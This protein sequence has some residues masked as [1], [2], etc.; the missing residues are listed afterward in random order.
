MNTIQPKNPRSR[1]QRIIVKRSYHYYNKRNS[2]SCCLLLMA[3]EQQPAAAWSWA[4]EI[5]NNRYVLYVSLYLYSNASFT[6]TFTSHYTVS[7]HY[8][9]R[10]DKRTSFGILSLNA[11]SLHFD[12]FPHCIPAPCKHL[13]LS[14][15][16]LYQ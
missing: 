1:K 6:L 4:I 16:A 14:S 9:M 13:L 11:K 5:C 10:G 2:I 12:D 15:P 7:K 8:W 3:I